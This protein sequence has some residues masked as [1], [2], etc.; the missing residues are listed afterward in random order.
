MQRNSQSRSDGF[1]QN[2]CIKSQSRQ[3]ELCNTNR[4]IAICKTKAS[5]RV[6]K[7]RIQNRQS[8]ALADDFCVSP[9]FCSEDEQLVHASQSGGGKSPERLI[10][11]VRCFSSFSGTWRSASMIKISQSRG[12]RKDNHVSSAIFQLWQSILVY[13]LRIGY[14]KT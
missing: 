3:N 5:Q 12:R 2:Y 11:K 14:S 6:M 9:C 7:G 8:Q 4:S 10:R 13:S 1:S